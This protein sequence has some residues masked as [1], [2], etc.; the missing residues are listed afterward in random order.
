MAD[1]RDQ[2]NST[3]D[4]LSQGI[5]TGAKAAK[6]ARNIAKAA[7]KAATGNFGAAKDVLK[8]EGLRRFL[9]FLLIFQFFLMFCCLYLALQ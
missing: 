5:K 6:S 2:H 9:I 8:D 3:S 4:D 7:G 1:Y